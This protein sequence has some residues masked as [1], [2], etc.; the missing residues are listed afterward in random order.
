MK[1][2]FNYLLIVIVFSFSFVFIAPV[3][4]SPPDDSAR[5]KSMISELEGKIEDANKRMIA[6]PN[7]LEELKALVEKY[8][9]QL[10]ELF[11]RDT[12]EDGNFNDN[13][14]WSV[15]SGEFSI[16]DAERLTSFVSTQIPE[17]QPEEQPQKNESSESEV[18]GILLDSIFG[19]PK[20]QEPVQKEPQ[21]QSNPVKPA[22]IFTECVF[23]PAFEMNM[24]F[25]SSPSG[26]M[27]LSL[28][29]SKNLTL[30]YLLKIN[31]NHSKDTPIEVVR[32]DNSRSFV[33]GASDTFPAI[34]DGQFHTLS[35]VRFVNGSMNV[36]IDGNVVLQTY[37]AY[38]RDNFTGL[39]ITNNG[40]SYEWDSFEIFKALKP[41]TQ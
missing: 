25:K 6:H 13:P 29:G 26:E 37:E 19:T 30:R 36:L 7:F 22:A 24:K 12:F 27:E 9:S 34:N 10:R 23:P 35:W 11:F 17:I 41:E 4:A 14:K 8:K 1:H 16:N 18:V 33:V 32:K 21:T 20:T 31:A 15:K 39:G 2:T 40:G 3:T 28:L 38:Y 5:L